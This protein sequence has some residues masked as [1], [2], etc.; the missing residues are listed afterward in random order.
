[1]NSS[2][3]PFDLGTRWSLDDFSDNTNS[4][5]IVETEARLQQGATTGYWT[6]RLSTAAAFTLS[7]RG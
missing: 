6:D 3:H 4:S 2:N 7:E 5:K 1:M